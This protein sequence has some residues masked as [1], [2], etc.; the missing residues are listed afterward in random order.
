ML[1]RAA[2]TPPGGGRVR[3]DA[4]RTGRPTGQVLKPGKGQRSFALRVW[5]YGKREYLTLGR[6][7]DGWTTQQAERELQIV[8]RDVDLGVWG[9]PLPNGITPHKLRHVLWGERQVAPCDL[10]KEL[11]HRGLG[12]AGRVQGRRVAAV[13][14]APRATSV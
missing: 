3:H 8:L 12:C 7:E 1:A 11:R 9:Q 6:P 4:P 13:V 10:A 5:A 14:I 2:K